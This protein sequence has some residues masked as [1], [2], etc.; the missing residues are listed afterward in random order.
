MVPISTNNVQPRA[1]TA[2]ANCP[3]YELRNLQVEQRGDALLISGNVSS[4]YHKQL[5]QE[6]V[7]SVCKD[8]DVVNSIEVE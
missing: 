1:Q 6:L 4:Y 3:V 7:R 2:L 8:S 5:A